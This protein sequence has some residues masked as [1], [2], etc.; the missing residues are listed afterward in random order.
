[1][2]LEDF[3]KVKRLVEERNRL[4]DR[5]RLILDGSWSVSIKGTYCDEYKSKLLNHLIIVIDISIDDVYRELE[6]L[7]VIIGEEG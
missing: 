4:I 3:E 6:T 5:K 7:G 1:M 2:R